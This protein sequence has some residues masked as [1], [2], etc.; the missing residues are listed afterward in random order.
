MSYWPRQLLH[1]T[2]SGGWLAAEGSLDLSYQVEEAIGKGARLDT[3]LGG[4]V[5]TSFRALN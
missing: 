5:P 1:N 2:N 3:A 4:A